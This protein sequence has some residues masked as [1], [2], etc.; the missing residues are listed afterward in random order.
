[1]AEESESSGSEE[2]EVE[3]EDVDPAVPSILNGR[4]Y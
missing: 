3:W 4:F 1:M 2:S